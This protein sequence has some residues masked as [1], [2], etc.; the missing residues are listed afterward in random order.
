MNFFKKIK[1]TEDIVVSVY[2][3]LVI[4]IFLFRGIF[5]ERTEMESFYDI[6]ILSIFLIG[7]ILFKKLQ[8]IHDEIKGKN[9]EKKGDENESN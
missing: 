9:I 4:I 2:L 1:I 3:N 8:K 6:I 5:S 7:L